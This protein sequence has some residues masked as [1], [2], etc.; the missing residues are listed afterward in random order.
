MVDDIR[1]I[2]LFSGIGG[3]RKGLEQAGGFRCVWSN[4]INKYANQ[5][6]TKNFGE[7]GHYS[8]DIKG[9]NPKDIPDFDLLCAGFPCQAFSSSGKRRG[10]AD[11]RGTLF[12]EICRIIEI[13]KPRLLLLENVKGLI[14]H[15]GGRTLATILGWLENLGYWWEYRVLDSQYFGVPQRRER[16]FIIGHLTGGRTGR[17]FP[18][19]EDG[20]IPPRTEKQE[21]ASTL[22]VAGHSGGLHSQMNLI[23]S[24]H[25]E[26][27]RGFT[28]IEKERLQGFPDGWTEGVSKSQRSKCL[29]NA[30]TVNVIEFLGRRLRACAL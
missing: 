17:V 3:V 26:R 1:F 5:I 28:N 4:D 12:F 25:G 18:L 30:V 23:A 20:P 7:A 14:H 13:K 9:V 19:R 8:G 11:P 16:V 2:D 29:G 10:F 6:Y 21:T 15:D 22:M 27:I 24:A